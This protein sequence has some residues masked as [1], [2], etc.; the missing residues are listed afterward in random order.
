[1]QKCGVGFCGSN[2]GSRGFLCHE[3]LS[4]VPE[5]IKRQLWNEHVRHRG[6]RQQSP[7]FNELLTKAVRVAAERDRNNHLDRDKHTGLRKLD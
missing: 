3:H 5:G 2:V 6:P 1:M 4:L 7:K